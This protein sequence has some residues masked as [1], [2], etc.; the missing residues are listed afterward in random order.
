MAFAEINGARLFYT[1]EGVGQPLVLV[2]GSGCDSYDWNYQLPELLPRFRVI[3][4]DRR[5]HGH[6]SA[7]ETGYSARQEASDLAEL[8]KEIGVG[9]TVAIGHSTGGAVVAALAANFPDKVRGLVA[10]DPSYGIPAAAR[11]AFEGISAGLAG[12]NGHEVYRSLFDGFYTPS[13]PA[14]LRPWHT[15][16]IYSVPKHALAAAVRDTALAEDQFFFSPE[17][18]R[19]LSR[20]VCPVLTIRR[21]SDGMPTPNWD[22]AQFQH[23]Y[24]RSI[25]WSDCGHWLHQERPDDF[26]YA[27]TDWLDGLP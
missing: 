6:S 8:L 12:P 23:P 22:L 7:P 1:D 17:T 24:S 2:H 13:S 16:R 11:V 21:V 19:L 25:A 3:A 5:G 26:N 4:Y 27:L 15:R 9:Q 14:H 10:V 18:E 20:I